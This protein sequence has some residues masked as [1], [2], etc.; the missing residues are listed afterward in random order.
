MRGLPERGEAKPVDAAVAQADAVHA[1]R[2]CDDDVVR[3]VA[4]DVAALRQVS[5]AREAA[6][7]FIHGSALL[8][9]AHE[10]HAFAP[11][12]FHGKD[13]SGNAGPLVGGSAAEDFAVANHAGEGVYGPSRARRHHVEMP[14]EMKVGTR[15][16]AFHTAN[17]LDA[18]VTRCMFRPAFR[19]HVA[20][21]VAELAQ[22]SAHEL[23]AVAVIFTRAD[24]PWG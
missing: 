1:Q 12:G 7:F 6:V 16:R 23:R 9:G 21:F 4:A 17:H 3:A 22:P 10:S 18:R 8:Y 5:H 20:G 13:G 14:V 15:R 11:D 24:S 19:G 2:L